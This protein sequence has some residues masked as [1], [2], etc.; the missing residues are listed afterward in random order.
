MKY[1]S[2][3]GY[4]EPTGCAVQG[5]LCTYYLCTCKDNCPRWT[6]NTFGFS[7]MRVCVGEVLNW[8]LTRG[9]IA[10]LP[11]GE[12][13]LTSETWMNVVRGGFNPT[14]TYLP[15]P[16]LSNVKS[17]EVFTLT[18]V[19]SRLWQSKCTLC[20]VVH[21]CVMKDSRCSAWHLYVTFVATKSAWY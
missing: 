18:F 20:S 16:T 21:G 12:L 4:C 6:P 15:P 1:T 2:L 3:L 5:R 7:A 10:Q 11:V 14:R 17:P 9:S 19:I 13:D 8:F